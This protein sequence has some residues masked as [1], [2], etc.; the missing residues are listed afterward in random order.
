[1][2]ILTRIASL[3]SRSKRNII[4]IPSN[5]SKLYLDLEVY[6]EVAQKEIGR[7]LWIN[8]VNY[9][10]CVNYPGVV[11]DLWVSQSMPSLIDVQTS[12]FPF[13]KEQESLKAFI[14]Q[15]EKESENASMIVG[16]EL[17][18]E[19]GFLAACINTFSS[20]ERP[21]YRRAIIAASKKLLNEAEKYGISHANGSFISHKSGVRNEI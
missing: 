12:C 19:K 1:M 11:T 18:V 21:E 15:A 16:D 17:Y 20:K 2:R 3:L 8:R 5:E 14:L 10:T 6:C 9:F 13:V 7:D 4:S